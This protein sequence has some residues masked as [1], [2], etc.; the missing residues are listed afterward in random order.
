MLLQRGGASG[1]VGL[2]QITRRA[3]KRGD[4]GLHP[5]HLELETTPTGE[6]TCHQM[7]KNVRLGCRL[8]LQALLETRRC[9]LDGGLTRSA[10]SLGR[11]MDS[12]VFN[13]TLVRLRP[14]LFYDQTR[15]PQA[16]AQVTG[17]HWVVK[18]QRPRVIRGPRAPDH[19]GLSDR[20]HLGHLGPALEH[21]ALAGKERGLLGGPGFTDSGRGGSKRRLEEPRL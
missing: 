5:R 17:L 19:R 8:A 20:C 2:H 12:G 18:L 4:P 9:R 1:N 11:K 16:V 13:H 6:T 15:I 3:N 10:R 7:T 14:V 21:P